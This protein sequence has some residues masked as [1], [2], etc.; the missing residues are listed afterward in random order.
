MNCAL[1]TFLKGFWEEIIENDHKKANET[2][3]LEITLSFGMLFQ[4][5]Q[6]FILHHISRS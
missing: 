3:M 6:M 2:S 4:L 5:I 1:L